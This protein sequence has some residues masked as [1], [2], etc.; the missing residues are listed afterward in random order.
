MTV[1]IQHGVALHQVLTAQEHPVILK[2]DEKI[3]IDVLSAQPNM[4][5][6]ILGI[7]Y[8]AIVMHHWLCSLMARRL[9]PHQQKQ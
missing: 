5:L 3:S 8:R 4:R 2:T 7:H 1:I 9:L 6:Q